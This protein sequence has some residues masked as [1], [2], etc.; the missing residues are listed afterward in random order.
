MIEEKVR[1]EA[2]REQT[3]IQYFFGCTAEYPQF[4]VLVYLFRE[5]KP[6]KEL[7]RVKNDGL[8]FH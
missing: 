5:R 3:Y 6:T 2:N 8:H 4:F 1:Q 7:I